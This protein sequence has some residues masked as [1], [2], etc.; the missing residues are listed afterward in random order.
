[1]LSTITTGL[2]RVDSRLFRIAI[3]N[4]QDK[5]DKQLSKYLQYKDF[6]Y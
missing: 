2:N 5:V 6:S 3:Y 1:M 4:G